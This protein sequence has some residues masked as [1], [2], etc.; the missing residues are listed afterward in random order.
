M[1][2]LTIRVFRPVTLL[3]VS[4]CLIAATTSVR[5]SRAAAKEDTVKL[6]EAE[7]LVFE[8]NHM[9]NTKAGLVLNYKFVREG[10]LGDDFSDSVKLKVEGGAKATVKKVEMEFFTGERR[11]PY[12]SFSYVEANPLITVFFNRDAW[13]LARRIKAKGTANYLRNRILDGFG[14]V[15]TM[16]DVSCDVNGRSYPAK[17]IKFQPFIKDE[18]AHHLVHYAGVEYKLIL[19]TEVPGGICSLQSIIPDPKEAIPDYYVAKLK[20]QGMRDLASEAAKVNKIMGDGAPVV[21]ET[22]SFI[23]VSDQ[24][25]AA[26]G[27]KEVRGQSKVND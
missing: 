16:E 18:N 13:S 8:T 24:V 10:K 12:P 25:K 4:G 7:T 2:L 15:K 9:L 22:L 21:T 17:L 5:E 19:S 26:E 20:K 14:N 23:S 11:R 6:N 27:P 1:K 3:L